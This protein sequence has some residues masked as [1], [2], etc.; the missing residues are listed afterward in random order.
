MA[1]SEC[2]CKKYSCESI[3]EKIDIDYVKADRRFRFEKDETGCIVDGGI[4]QGSIQNC[5]IKLRGH[6][7]RSIANDPRPNGHKRHFSK[8]QGFTTHQTF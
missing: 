6:D 1:K 4:A 7:L 5:E 2:F 3:L 8:R